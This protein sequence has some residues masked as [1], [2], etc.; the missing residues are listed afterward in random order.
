MRKKDKENEM[1]KQHIIRQQEQKQ[2][3][4]KETKKRES[5]DSRRL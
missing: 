4:I 1:L 2:K 3:I 5:K